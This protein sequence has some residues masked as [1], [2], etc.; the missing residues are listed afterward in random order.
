MPWA[1]AGAGSPSTPHSSCHSTQP[2]P[3]FH[4]RAGR[5]LTPSCPAVLVVVPRSLPPESHAG[6]RAVINPCVSMPS[7]CPRDTGFSP[8]ERRRRDKINNWIVQLSKIIPD[9]NADNS[10]TGAVRGGTMV[11]AGLGHGEI[12]LRL[13]VGLG[14]A[15]VGLR[16][17]VRVGH[18]GVELRLEL[19]LAHG[20]AVL[21]LGAMLGHGGVELSQ[22]RAGLNWGLRAGG[23]AIG[24]G[25]YGGD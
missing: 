10:K 1:W 15:G 18:G 25:C 22:V 9:C 4:P 2:F 23:G 11:G 24:L 13:R 12:G 21:K 3:Q 5:I 20:G 19:A 17:E 8:V 16:L 14:H 6:R 7:P